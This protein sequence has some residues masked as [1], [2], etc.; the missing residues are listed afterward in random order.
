[1]DRAHPADSYD[2]D[3]RNLDDYL[4]GWHGANGGL[5]SDEQRSQPLP[6]AAQTSQPGWNELEYHDGR[7][8]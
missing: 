8:F 7:P 5:P 1:M 2:H 4:G 3:Q 6:A